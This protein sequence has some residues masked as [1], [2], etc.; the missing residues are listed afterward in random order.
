MFKKKFIFLAYALRLLAIGEKQLNYMYDVTLWRET[1]PL[2][3]SPCTSAVKVF[4][5]Q[6][7][8]HDVDLRRKA[9][10]RAHDDSSTP[11]L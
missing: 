11:L 8:L 10:L 4:D 9:H 1:Y 6:T 3:Y 5:E 2:V 7:V